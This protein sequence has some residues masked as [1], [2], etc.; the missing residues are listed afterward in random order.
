MYNI[1]PTRKDNKKTESRL[2]LETPT[3]RLIPRNLTPISFASSFSKSYCASI[4][5]AFTVSLSFP[6][7]NMSSD[8]ECKVSD[9]T[10]IVAVVV[11]LRIEWF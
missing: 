3:L 4:S 10:K 2:I 11:V 6:T 9:V 1:R 7:S 5:P 8:T